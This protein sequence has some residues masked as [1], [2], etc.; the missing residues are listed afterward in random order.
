MSK[1]SE[2]FQARVEP[3]TTE[4]L[5]AIA[6]KTGLL[7]GDKPAPGKVLEIISQHSDAIA[8]LIE[9]HKKIVDV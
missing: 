4:R 2:L 9:A 6:A 5:K 8:A 3:G 7:Y 1:S